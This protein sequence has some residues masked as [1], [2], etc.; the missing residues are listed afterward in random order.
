MRFTCEIDMD[1]DAFAEC[2]ACALAELLRE[3]AAA[4]DA[5]ATE[6]ILR[7]ANGNTA[8]RWRIEP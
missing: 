5:A 8:G 1:N 6:G 2:P 7:D 3:T 4:V